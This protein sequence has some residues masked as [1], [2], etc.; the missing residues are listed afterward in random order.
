MDCSE[1]SRNL[2]ISM[3]GTDIETMSCVWFVSKIIAKGAGF[4][5]RPVLS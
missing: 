5:T 1:N 4:D 2:E 3:Y